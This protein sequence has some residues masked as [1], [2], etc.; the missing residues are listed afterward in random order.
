M[1]GTVLPGNYTVT[2][3]VPND[4]ETSFV[5]GCGG[6]GGVGPIPVFI[7]DEVEISIPPGV[8]QTCPW[9][10]VPSSDAAALDAG[11]PQSIAALTGTGSLTMYAYNCPAGF[12]VNSVDANP[13]ASC[14]PAVG[15]RLGMYDGLDDDGREFETGAA[16]SDTIDKLA[17]GTYAITLYVDNGVTATFAWDCYDVAGASS[18][19]DPLVMGSR[20]TYNLADGAQVRCDWFNVTGGVGRVIVNNH[21]CDNQV[22]AYTLTYEQLGAQCTRDTG[23]IDFT[24]VS[25]VHQEKL[26]AT[27]NPLTPASFA[28]VPSG[29]VAVVEQILTDWVVPVVF[30]QVN[31]ENGDQVS[32]PTAMDVVVGRQI[33]F[34]LEPGQVV[35][36]DWF[37]V[38][39]GITGRPAHLIRLPGRSRP[40]HRRPD[41]LVLNCTADPGIV[42]FTVADGRLFLETKTVTATTN[43]TIWSSVPSGTLSISE[44]LP[45][46]YGLPVV[47]CKIDYET[48]TNVTPYQQVMVN[49]GPRVE[50]GVSPGQQLT[51][52]W[53]NAPGGLGMVSIWK[54]ACPEGVDVTTAT[55]VQLDALCGEDIPTIDFSLTSGSFSA[56]ASSTNLFRYADF[57]AVPAGIQTITESVPDGHG[58]PVVYCQ[59]QENS[60]I[61]VRYQ[62]VNVSNGDSIAWELKANQWLI[63]D[64][65]N[66]YDPGGTVVVNKYE[67]PAGTTYDHDSAWYV[68][69][70]TT[71]QDSIEFRLTHSGGLDPE[72]PANGTV[73][74]NDIPLGP[75]SIQEFLPPE[76]G[77]PVV[78]CG[79]VSS[80]GGPIDAVAKR[81][82]SKGGYV[83]TRFDYPNT[84]YLCYW[85][86]IPGGPGEVTI[87]KWTCPPGYDLYAEGADP[88]ED[89]TEA[90]NGIPFTLGGPAAQLEDSTSNGQVT[91]GELDPGP[92]TVTES[93]PDGTD[94]V[95]VLDCYGQTMGELRPYP[96]SMGETL[97][98]GV[99]AGEKI[100]CYWYNVPEYDEGRLTVYKY[101][102]STTT[103]TSDVDCE[104]FEGGQTF[105]LVMWDGDSWEYVTAGTTD[106][107]GQYTWVDLPPGPY[108]L[109]EADREWCHMTSDWISDDG[110]WLGVNDGEDT[111]VKVYNCGG[112]PNDPGNPGKPG[113]PGETPTKYPNTGVGPN[114]S[115]PVQELP[116]AAPLAG[117]LGLL[118]L[119]PYCLRKRTVTV[120]YDC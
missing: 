95:F 118:V 77:E 5:L 10:N 43:P 115:G 86:N 29:Y 107:A 108:W 18:R 61:V 6:G 80:S 119:R 68:E 39:R 34:D 89:C 96:L 59:V 73:E 69:N 76:Y 24:V 17:A 27:Q 36:C 101:V 14:T 40:L 109:D 42:D 9:F 45:G 100:E 52:E 7:D 75:V 104:I 85:Y 19:T 38:F 87:Y 98:I 114:E 46:G 120:R 74:W 20:L 94:Y 35:T 71:P 12:D 90:A 82:E 31:M 49:S 65:Y 106:G 117:L 54:Q 55:R 83:E 13:Q 1:F 58:D 8:I 110:N 91:F 44:E 3:D 81:V 99:G 79:V 93:V 113:T 66:T 32:P 70:C 88:M 21:G 97:N 51:C 50:I 30:C 103:F 63:C 11:T 56:T 60:K 111:I 33:S 23:P 22:P 57:N 16:G 25:D 78:F 102:C 112:N 41:R 47:F 116:A 2:Q 84:R 67:C 64:W 48:T 37:N 28:N 62:K 15:A 53:F 4:I 105:D 72:F 26:P 92:Y